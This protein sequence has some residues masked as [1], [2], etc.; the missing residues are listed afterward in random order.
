[1]PPNEV[2]SEKF[3]VVFHICSD[4]LDPRFKENNIP[5]D[6]IFNTLYKPD[7]RSHFTMIKMLSLLNKE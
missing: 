1:L 5:K 2:A 3:E 4:A 6:D 7:F